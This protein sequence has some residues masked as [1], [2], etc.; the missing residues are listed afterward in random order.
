MTGS[1]Q[2][3]LDS[4][5]RS[6]FVRAM[7]GAREGFLEVTC[8][9]ARHEFGDPAANARASAVVLNPGFFRKLL[10][11]G[12]IALG[13]SYMDGDWSTPDLTAVVRFAVRNLANF[14]ASNTWLSSIA[15][16]SDNL[17]HRRNANTVAQ[18]RKNIRAHYDLSND[19][20]RLFLDSRM[21]Y[22]CAWF[23]NA[24]DSLETAQIA[25]LDR[26]CRKL[27]LAPGDHLLEIGTGWGGL[28]VHAARHYGCRVTTTTISREQHDYAR[29][30]IDR[31][32][33]SGRIELLLEDY[34]NLRGSYNKL[35]S[36]EMFEA[37]G[38][39]YYDTYF[40][41]CDRLLDRDGAMLLQTI[42]INEQSFDRYRRKSDWIQKRIFP[43]GELASVH[44]ILTSLARSTRLSLFHAEDM[45]AHYART[46]A[47]WRHRFHASL[48][49][50]RAMGFDDRFIRM[51]DLYLAYSEG[52]FLERHVSAAQLLLDKTHNRRALMN[53]PWRENAASTALGVDRRRFLVR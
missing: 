52:A 16:F 43:G 32:G 29:E 13:E 44:G 12:D 3:K 36:I 34:R 37:V 40:G 42:T 15:R 24:D 45:G 31:E 27:E 38:F 22:S 53:E 47:A 8:P 5:A 14:D 2:S 11:G 19:F 26:V 35:A 39:D 17:S 49:R 46:L 10:A 48:D 18:S 20:F 6:I 30:L 7:Q 1:F 23:D 41:C 50:V 21:V 28:A 51:W 25:K 33:L 9:D 4:A